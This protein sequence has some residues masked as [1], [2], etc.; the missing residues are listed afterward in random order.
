VEHSNSGEER[1]DFAGELAMN[2]QAASGFELSIRRVIDAPRASVWRC[3]TEGDLLKQWYCPKPWYVSRADIDVRPGGASFIIMNGPNGEEMPIP[4]QYL[5]VVHGQR[6]VF[7][8]AFSGD[9]KPAGKPF[10][11]GFVE[12]SDAPGGKTGMIW[13]ARHWTEEDMK[14]H[15]EMG[16]EGGWNAATDQLNE[17]VRSL[18]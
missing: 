14:Q 17:L 7:T 8:D 4:G 16:F 6:L 1:D 18:K 9:W 15:L 12:L 5:E 10:M 2:A 13:G 11:V 3:W